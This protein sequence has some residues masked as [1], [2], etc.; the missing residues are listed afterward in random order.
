MNDG[1]HRA[2]GVESAD[3]A[4]VLRERGALDV[5]SVRA[6]FARLCDAIGAGHDTGKVQ[7]D[8]ALERVILGSSGRDGA[9]FAVEVRRAAP[10][11]LA[12]PAW[13]AP[14]QLT[15]PGAAPPPSTDVWSLGLIA[16]A[17]LTGRPYW[18]AATPEASL[19]GAARAALFDEVTLGSLVPA[20]EREAEL[21]AGALLP[22]GFD[23]WF[24][25]CVAR[26]PRERFPDARAAGASFEAL[27]ASLQRESS[28]VLSPRG[29][30]LPSSELPA[31]RRILVI[32][33]DP[34]ALLLIGHHLRHAGYDVVTAS[35]GEEGLALA[36]RTQPA[37]ILL[38]FMLPDI[39]GPEVLRRLRA[40][41][42][43]D[44]VP[45]I[46]LTATEL[47][48]HIAEGFRAGANDYL[49]KPVDVRL[50][51]L[52]IEAAIGA[53][54]TA[55]RATVIAVRHQK[56]VADLEEA[57]AEQEVTL[58]VLPASWSGWWAVGGVAPSGMVGGDLIALYT[59]AGG[60]RTAVV[61]DVAG[62]GAGAALVGATVRATL[63]LLLRRHEL[64]EAV[65]ALNEELV[66]ASSRHACLAAVQVRG[67]DVTI[68]NA[69]LPPVCVAR[70]GEPIH[71]V[72]TSGIPPGLLPD[73]AYM[74]TS[75][76]A[77]PGDRIAVV[78]DG[79]V[80]PF[81][82]I[83][84][85]LPILRDLGAFEPG[86]WNGGE[87]PLHV[88]NLLRDHLERLSGPQPDDAT[89]LLMEAGAELPSRRTGGV[90][91]LSVPRTK[92]TAR[93][94]AVGRRKQVGEPR[95]SGSRRRRPGGRSAA[96]GAA[97]AG[98]GDHG[99]RAAQARA[100]RRA[101]LGDGRRGGSRA[102]GGRAG[103][104]GSARLR[105]SNGGGGRRGRHGR[106]LGRDDGCGR[107]R[108]GGRRRAGGRH[109][110]VARR[111]VDAGGADDPE[112]REQRD[113]D[114]GAFELETGA[115]VTT[116]DARPRRE[117]H[118]VGRP[119]RSLGVAR[120]R[121]GIRGAPVAL[122]IGR[123]RRR[124]RGAVRGAGGGGRGAG[125][126]R[127]EPGHLG[128]AVDGDLA[129]G[130]RVGREREDELAD[131]LVAV[132]AVAGVR[133]LEHLGEALGDV[134]AE[135]ADGGGDAGE[136]LGA[137][138]GERVGVE[139][140]LAGEQLVERDA[141]RVDVGPV[142]DAAGLLHL[143]RRHVERRAH[144]GGG[145]GE[146]VDLVA[147]GLGDAEVEHLDQR[148]AVGPPGEEEVGGL[149]VAVDDAVAVRLGER[150]AAL[151]DVV[152]RV[153]H[154]EHALR[155][156]VGEVAPLQ[157]LHHH[158]RRAGVERA[159]VGD[160]GDVLA[161]DAHGVLGLAQEAGRVLGVLGELREEELEGHPL[162]QRDV[163][164][165]DDD[166]HASLADDALDAV[167]PRE[168][169]AGDGGACGR[170]LIRHGFPSL[171]KASRHVPRGGRHWQVLPRGGRRRGDGSS[172]E[173]ASAPRLTSR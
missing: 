151:D 25:R 19:G 161:L 162:V 78:S 29:R 118:A 24:A 103:H 72:A 137:E 69:G 58:A 79:L 47:A 136:D 131:G 124:R 98:R 96:S 122:V 80:E 158:V 36:R 150:V 42:A 30:R 130:R 9:P 91:A 23:T 64:V 2:L 149:D 7:G 54:D 102:R 165:L 154:V 170:G 66:A 127:L 148:R 26:D 52:R 71:E 57:R 75:F 87:Q 41:E 121:S 160:A 33:D 145:L 3:L 48:S 107:R 126:A 89:L 164:R 166:A 93:L 132:G 14:E 10:T 104:A 155:E 16:F 43:T 115:A 129:A 171:K 172:R 140:L 141:Q 32:D 55:R 63:G 73:Q 119:V 138:L 116:E 112:H 110:G 50:L 143:L 56:L 4:T 76:V 109:G 35:T 86:R 67:R 44:D 27:M 117:R 40:E 90:R 77:Q 111:E 1:V 6:I 53:R 74:S 51:S 114:E 159:H 120:H 147:R 142:V 15:G 113:H 39:D 18:R 123:L 152:D 8:L 82:F 28:P 5:A 61:V 146:V 11:T 12:D 100:R 108:R 139:G 153:G 134:L 157:E 163:L 168:D 34:M 135:G 13:R 173:G 99:Q 97:A 20:S 128:D 68:V 94:R 105:G 59:G 21:G 46:L 125:D 31:I 169:L 45:V 70:R 65:S 101:R 95:R 85:A 84:E 92:R 144:G 38:D 37:L 106:R 167:L 88:A 62:H 156:E 133:L 49:M 83:D 17:L 60:E 22:H 81:G